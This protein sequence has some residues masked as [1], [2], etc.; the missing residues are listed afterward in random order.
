MTWRRGLASTAIALHVGLALS[1]AAQPLDPHQPAV[2]RRSLTWRLH[3]DSVAWPGPGADFF[4]LY[5]AGV[6]VRRG[7][8]PYVQEESPRTTPYYFRY[9]YAPVVAHTLGYA[10]A[11][12]PPRTAYLLWAAVIEATLALFL[13]TWRR[14]TADA[15]VRLPGTCLLLVSTPY[16][17]ELHL[18]QFTF[19]ATALTVT[20]VIWTTRGG[21]R[22]AGPLLVLAGVCLKMFP[23]A[24][25]PAL[26]RRGARP[27][28]AGGFAAAAIIGA[29]AILFPGESAELVRLTAVDDTAFPHPGGL[30]LL[31]V[32]RL[33]LAAAGAA[34]SPAVWEHLAPIGLVTALV[35][36]SVLALRRQVT[37]VAGFC[38]LLMTF[39]TVFYRAAEHYFS[40]VLLLAIVLTGE[41]DR[42]RLSRDEWLAWLASLVLLAL[43]TPF[44]FLPD[45]AEAWSTA[46]IFALALAKIAPALYI[47]AVGLL[48]GP[49]VSPSPVSR[50]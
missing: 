46:A 28:F 48:Q 5:H 40:S 23:M 15:T 47:L 50:Q 6:Q 2:T 14:H 3:F 37:P 32:L 49:T 42:T 33:A 4:A 41:L 30:G 21:A 34:P 20:G 45:R 10:L 38:L 27:A 19:V 39:L 36:V 25:L 7:V 29:G 12:F 17:L 1:V 13:W 22:L 11:G 44:Y 43:P 31:N 26:A 24:G 9:L 16:F 35:V 18:G 8:S